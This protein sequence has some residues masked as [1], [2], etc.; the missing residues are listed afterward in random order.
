MIPLSEITNIALD[1]I[2]NGDF[3]NLPQ[4]AITGL[5][6]DFQYSWL[7][8][9]KISYNYSMLD[10]AR[11]LCNGHNKAVF[12]ATNCKGIEEIRKK[13]SV[14]INKRNKADDRVIISLNFDGKQINAEWIDIEQYLE[15][16]RVRTG[17]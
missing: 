9:F 12:K 10:I 13:F 6:N 7:K 15:S 5:L 4:L 14:Y 8:K 2:T 17:A 3:V 16:N 11:N 1:E